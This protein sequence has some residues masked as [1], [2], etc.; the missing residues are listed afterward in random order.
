[1]ADSIPPSSG[2]IGELKSRLGEA[3]GGAGQEAARPASTGDAVSPHAPSDPLH[4]RQ[5]LGGSAPLYSQAVLAT[6]TINILA[7]T[8]SLVVM[9]VYDRVLPNQAMETLTALAIGAVLAAMFEFALKLLRGVLIDAASHSSD[10]KLANLLFGRVVGAKLSL[11]RNATG[12]RVNTLREFETLRDFFTSATLTVLGDLPFALLF[13]IVIGLVAGPLVLVPL[14]AMPLLV[15]GSLLLHRP[16]ARLTAES[17]R[18]TAQKNAVLV[19][20]LVGL[21]T[22]KALGAEPW[23]T[24]QW[25]KAVREHCRV[26]LRTRLLSALAH[27]LV[28]FVQGAAT[29]ALLVYGVILVGRGD[30]TAGA[31]MAAMTL[32]G[33]VLAPVA[34]GAMILSRLHQV[35]IAW[36]A[37]KQ[38]ADAPQERPDGAGF[39]QPAQGFGAYRFENVSF[40]YAPDSAPALTQASFVIGRGE[41]VGIIGTIGCGKSTLLKLMLKLH[42]PQAGRILADDLALN[43]VD[44]DQLRRSIGFVE[45][46]PTLFAGTIRANLVLHRPET[47]DAEILRACQVAGAMGWI[48]RMP[49]GFDTVLGERGAGLSAGQRQSLALARA[50][51]GNPQILMLD[52]PTSDMDGRSESEVM[53]RLGAA[54]AGQTLILVTHR[55]ALLELVDR[56]IVLDGGRVF[57]DGPKASVLD[58]LRLRYDTQAREAAAKAAGAQAPATQVSTVEEAAAPGA[59]TPTVGTSAPDQPKPQKRAR[60][61]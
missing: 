9:N 20:T 27:N 38:L 13:I 42:E 44:P 52:E 54:L 61:A 30:V 46:S 22:I 15:L 4:W 60:R 19:E 50:L 17:F 21:D 1:L 49:R 40:Q 41:R 33:R 11:A 12:V 8:G 36:T 31:L 25:D 10:I 45:Q 34:Q 43:G 14:V 23:A 47:G 18:D 6:I 56:L 32:M 28:A 53:Q 26:G 7:L 3:F 35:K 48:G 51:V 2:T 39:V 5:F 59:D 55:P 29:V 58:L 16:L 57:A 24:S 37:L